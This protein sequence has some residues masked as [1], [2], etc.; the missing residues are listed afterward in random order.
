[1]ARST[2]LI[3]GA[4]VGIGRELARI[5]AQNGHDLIL[6]ARNVAQLDQVAAECRSLGSIT[7]RVLQ[8]DL[9]VPEAPREIFDE[10][11]R[12][13]LAID[14]LVNNAGFGNYGR[15]EDVELDADLRLLQ[16]NVVALTALT[17]LF[18]PDMLARR[19]GRIL[20]VASMAAFH[21]GP[22][23]STYYASKAYVLHFSEAIANECTGRGVTV[24]ALCPGPVKTEFQARAGIRGSR[25]FKSKAAM[26][27]RTVALAG[28][29]GLMRGRRIVVPGISNALLVRLSRFIPRKLATFVAGKMNKVH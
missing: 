13:E 27:A 5:F 22:W 28:Y 12:E 14:V 24:T 26:D 7:A 15:F 25:L 10:L 1:M 20:N 6:V 23:M 21:A 18:L 17:K 2:A 11:K 19:S 29:S 9:S 4:S 8:K 3:T 16:V